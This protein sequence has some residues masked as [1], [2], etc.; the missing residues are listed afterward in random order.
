[1]QSFRFAA[2]HQYVFGTLAS[3]QLVQKFN[4]HTQ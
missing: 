3:C 4:G 2:P 1:L